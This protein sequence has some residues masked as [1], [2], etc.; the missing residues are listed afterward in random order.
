MRSKTIEK[1]NY[2]SNSRYFD[3]IVII[4]LSVMNTENAPEY[5][6]IAV[7]KPDD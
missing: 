4:A 5:L 2:I 7:A 3:F 6:A 1:Q